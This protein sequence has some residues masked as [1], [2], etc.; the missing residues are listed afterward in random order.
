ML[1]FAAISLGLS[2]VLVIMGS[3]PAAALPLGSYV[4]TC[5]ACIAFHGILSCRCL[6]IS[7]AWIDTR[8][9]YRQCGSIGN[10]NG[11]LYCE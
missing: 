8:I 5:N 11:H 9:R 7:G 2:A 1:K 3:R 6:T 4:R 10:G